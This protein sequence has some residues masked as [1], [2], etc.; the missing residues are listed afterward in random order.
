[1]QSVKNSENVINLPRAYGW[2]SSIVCDIRYKVMAKLDDLSALTF[3]QG[4]KGWSQ[5]H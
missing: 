3:S 2:R 5:R 4:L 1:M